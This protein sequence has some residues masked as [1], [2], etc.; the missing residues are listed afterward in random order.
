MR[1]WRSETG[2]SGTPDALPESLIG[3]LVRSKDAK[4]VQFCLGILSASLF[5]LAINT[6]ESPEALDTTTLFHSI[7][8][9]TLGLDMPEQDEGLPPFQATQVT[10]FTV[11]SMY[12]YLA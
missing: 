10:H 2:S 3:K 5:D 7:T 8:A 1:A 12:I 9:R 11:D 6:A 4:K